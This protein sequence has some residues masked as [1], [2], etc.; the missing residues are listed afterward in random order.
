MGADSTIVDPGRTATTMYV[1][2]PGGSEGAVIWS[3]PPNPTPHPP[4]SPIRWHKMLSSL[5][6]MLS[7][8]C[9]SAHEQRQI[10]PF[11]IILES[12]NQ[13]SSLT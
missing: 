1:N 6:K 12:V 11:S 3:S 9:S 4:C 7:S 10:N 13:H 2:L 5:V 8:L